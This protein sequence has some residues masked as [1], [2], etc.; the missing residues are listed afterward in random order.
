[1]SANLINFDENLM[2]NNFW[3]KLGLRTKASRRKWWDDND[4]DDGDDDDGDDDDGD[5]DD[6]DVDNDDDDRA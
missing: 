2:T 1:M 4:N 3:G 5:D 6:G